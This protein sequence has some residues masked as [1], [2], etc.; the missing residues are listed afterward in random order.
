MTD[1]DNNKICYIVK[2]HSSP[3]LCIAFA[4]YKEMFATAS[5]DMTVKIWTFQNSKK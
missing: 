2:S 4:S 3:I 5:K 1:I